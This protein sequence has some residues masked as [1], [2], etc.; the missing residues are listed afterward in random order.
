MVRKTQVASEKLK[1]V[2]IIGS[3]TVN[4][5]FKEFKWD[6]IISNYETCIEH[7]SSMDTVLRLMRE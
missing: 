5:K 2:V 6:I 3:V 4:V 1:I 7:Y